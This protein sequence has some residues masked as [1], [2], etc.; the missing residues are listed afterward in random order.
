ML[1]LK[2]PDWVNHPDRTLEELK[3]SYSALPFME[4]APERASRD[5]YRLR[6]TQHALKQV[7]K[8]GSD[9]V[10][11]NALAADMGLPAEPEPAPINPAKEVPPG[12]PERKSAEMHDH[13]H[14]NGGAPA[15]LL[16]AAGALALIIVAMVA[17]WA[18]WLILDDN[19]DDDVVQNPAPTA[20]AAPTQAPNATAA[21]TPAPT[22]VLS[23]EGTMP[24][25][26]KDASHGAWTVKLN[27]DIDN[28]PIVRDW[29]SRLCDPDPAHGQ[30]YPNIPNPDPGSCPFDVANGM[31]YGVANVP[32]CQQDMR[33]DFIVPAWHYRLITGD[34]GFLDTECHG[35]DGKGCALL[36]INVMDQ[37][38]TWRNQMADN[39]FTVPGRYWNGDKLDEG[40][41]ALVNHVSANML[42]M[43]TLAHPDEVLN[44]GED[45]AGA[46]CGTPNACGSVDFTVVVHA[47]DRI[48]A[49][50]HTVVQHP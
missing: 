32:F 22:V 37:S 44:A 9:A 14:D 30:T 38:Y 48:L 11:P 24:D 13:R 46:N 39:G 41:S 12:E 50:A 8:D 2:F 36:L 45:N 33:C 15:W 26:P 16:A 25:L 49:T 4:K 23:G 43:K 31:E 6:L 35:A 21:A 1:W 42:G 10:I 7:E 20:T 18:T 27:A 19:D 47:G 28:D 29:L 5:W 40:V 34:Y 3:E 17:V